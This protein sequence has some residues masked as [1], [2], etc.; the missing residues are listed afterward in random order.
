M[1]IAAA[2]GAG[3][4]L[5][6]E[7]EDDGTKQIY[8]KNILYHTANV[9]L[10]ESLESQKIS[11]SSSIKIFTPES[12]E[13]YCTFFDDTQ[14][15]SMIEY[16]TS[17]ELRDSESQFLGNIHIIGSPDTPKLIITIIQ[18]DPFMSELDDI[19]TVFKTTVEN[20]VCDCWADV[21]PDGFDSVDSW[22][23][24]IR[25]FHTSGELPKPTSKS[26]IV[27]LEDKKLQIELT[28][29]TEGYL[30]KLLIEN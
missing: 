13:K 19:K 14:K 7:P 12:L 17:T 20:I 5:T 22:I 25:E 18:T 29:N 9:E 21:S 23:D 27:S 28:T 8:D 15:Q 26:S 3:A 4:A 24:G 10:K 11:M 1:V 16:C 2:L 6:I 30:W